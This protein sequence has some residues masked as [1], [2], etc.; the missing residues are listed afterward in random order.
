MDR[1]APFALGLLCLLFGCPK[2]GAVE[3]Q[4]ADPTTLSGP[5]G[6][7]RTV[8]LSAAADPDPTLRAAAL[9]A[10]VAR[11][12]TAGGGEWGPRGTFDP[13]P[14][15]QREVTAALLARNGDPLARSHVR[16][17]VERPAV[18]PLSRCSAALRLADPELRPV[19]HALWAESDEP[20]T[21]APCALAAARL[22]DDLAPAALDAA[23]RSGE[24]PFEL[25]FYEDLA[26]RPS[27]GPASGAEAALL[28][29]LEAAMAEVEEGLSLPVAAALARLDSRAGEDALR[30]ALTGPSA[31]AALTAIDLL[32]DDPRAVATELLRRGAQAG[33]AAARPF[34]TVALVRRGAQETG[35]ALLLAI[36]ADRELRAAAIRAI[37]ES[38]ARGVGRRVARGA[39]ASVVAA[40]SDPDDV[41]RAAAVVALYQL[42]GGP[43][44]S[45]LLKDESNTVRLAAAVA[46]LP[47]PAPMAPL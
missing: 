3:V 27:P 18:D 23:L 37:G 20:F 33:P 6:D 12:P 32:D 17:L 42:G 14:W 26:R 1:R 13:S 46:L 29:A 39:R 21:V 22:G 10:L 7:P 28:P 24:L 8:L 38:A 41:V 34:A 2:Q 15:V 9:V 47:L 25:I 45:A 43:E 5:V 4:E 36:S 35:Q 40:L 31:E 16:V 19:V 44:L 30:A 11:E